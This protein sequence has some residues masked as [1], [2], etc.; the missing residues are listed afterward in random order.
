MI[1]TWLAGV[2][3]ALTPDQLTFR[4]AL[5]AGPHS[6]AIANPV[7]PGPI[8]IDHL[9]LGLEDPALEGVGRRSENRIVLWLHHR[10]QLLS[11]TAEAD[12]EP[13]TAT[14]RIND[15]PEGRW[16]LVWW[17]HEIAEPGDPIRIDHDGGD[18]EIETPEIRRHRAGWLERVRCTSGPR[19]RPLGMGHSA[20]PAWPAAPASLTAPAPALFA[21]PLR[22]HL[23]RP[24][25]HKS[26]PSHGS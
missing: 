16:Q 1:S 21:L 19:H 17:D 25:S 7:G 14:L 9:D 11:P 26:D 20:P 5:P 24:F 22:L 18:L 23:A 10:T 2:S 12:L 6:V 3:T 13:A 8:E 4:F 15:L